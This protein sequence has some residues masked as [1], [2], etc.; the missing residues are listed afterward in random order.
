M[1][2]KNVNLFLIFI[3][4]CNLKLLEDV[5]S[6]FFFIPEL[7]TLPGYLNSEF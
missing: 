7:V 2:V 4:G 5:Y 1:Y 3:G 6:F